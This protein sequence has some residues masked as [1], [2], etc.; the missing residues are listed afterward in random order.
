M[1]VPCK[2]TTTIGKTEAMFVSKGLIFLKY[3]VGIL[4]FMNMFSSFCIL[5]QQSSDFSR[6]LRTGNAGFYL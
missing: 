5:Q 3:T 1:F 2:T 6:G 4:Y